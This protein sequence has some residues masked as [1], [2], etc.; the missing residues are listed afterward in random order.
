MEHLAAQKARKDW[1]KVW[2]AL[3][4]KSLRKWMIP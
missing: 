3:D 4:R 1:P 2:K